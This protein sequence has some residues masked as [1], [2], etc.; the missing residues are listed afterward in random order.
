MIRSLLLGVTLIPM[1]SLAAEPA[2][3]IPQELMQRIAEETKVIGIMGLPGLA[4]EFKADD[5]PNTLQIV[6]LSKRKDGPSRVSD[7][8]EV[9]FLYKAS[10][11]TQQ[12]L[13]GE[14][15]ERKAR[16]RL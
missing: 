12:Q 13:I 9:I 8:G 1:A 3:A 14:A 2:P 6:F 11:R 5:D 4:S 16:R 15:F 7:D 10:D